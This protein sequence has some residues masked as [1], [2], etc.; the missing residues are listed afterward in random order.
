MFKGKVSIVFVLQGTQSYHNVSCYGGVIL[1][2]LY[3][4]FLTNKP[5]NMIQILFDF[6]FCGTCLKQKKVLFLPSSKLSWKRSSN[7]PSMS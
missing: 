2:M 4:W 1:F 5:Y 6:T 3:I 7:H